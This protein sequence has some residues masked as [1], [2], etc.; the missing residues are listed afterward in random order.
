MAKTLQRGTAIAALGA[1]LMVITGAFLPLEQLSRWGWILFLIGF[2]CIAAGLIPYRLL[3]RLEKKPNEI[4]IGQDGLIHYFQRG[5]ETFTIPQEMVKEIIY[6]DRKEIYGIGLKLAPSSQQKVIK[7]AG[8]LKNG[9]FEMRKY[10]C[11][12]FFPYFSRRSYNEL[13]EIL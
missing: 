10:G 6:I 4:V 5:Q 11:D 12:I 13:L 2:S 7:H 1:F 9:F 3:T 8:S